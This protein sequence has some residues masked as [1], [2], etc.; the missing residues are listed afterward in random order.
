MDTQRKVL[1]W[2]RHPGDFLNKYTGASVYTEIEGNSQFRFEGTTRDW[3]ETLTETIVDAH[4]RIIKRQLRAPNIIDVS[5]DLYTLLE[6]TVRFKKL[7]DSS[8]L[9][10]D[11]IQINCNPTIPS[12]EIRMYLVSDYRINVPQVNIEKL[13]SMQVIDQMTIKALNMNLI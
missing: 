7:N 5:R 13:D 3:Y 8:A 4:N 2:S 9:L 12:D 10:S 6:H 1:Y 11:Y